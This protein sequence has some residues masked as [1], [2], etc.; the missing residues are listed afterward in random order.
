MKMNESSLG[1][2]MNE[3]NNN[4]TT[5]TFS[6]IFKLKYIRHLI[7]KHVEVISKQ[8]SRPIGDRD[9]K[10]NR[11]LSGREIIKLPNLAMISKYAMPWCFIK[12]YLPPGIDNVLLE[13]RID[14]IIRYCIHR[15]AELDTLKHLI[16][17]WSPDFNPKDRDQATQYF[18]HLALNITLVGNREVLEFILKRYPKLN[19]TNTRPRAAERGYLSI[20]KL[21]DSL[22]SQEPEYTSS[23][24]DKVVANGHLHILE[25]LYN[26]GEDLPPWLINT[27]SANGHLSIVE[28]LHHHDNQNNDRIY[29]AMDRAAQGGFFEIVKFLHFNRAEGCSERAM[30]SAAQIGNL[31]ILKFL[32]LNRTEGCT[33]NAM[34]QASKNGFIDIVIFLH[35]NRTEGCTVNAMDNAN[36]LEIIQY[37]HNHRTEGCT[38]A[39]MARATE[40][41]KLNI[42]QWLHYNRTEGCT[43]DAM[44][45]AIENGHIDIVK[46][47]Y[48]N[49][50]EGCI[51]NILDTAVYRNQSLEMISYVLD[52]IGLGVQF[53]LTTVNY[54]AINGR[55]DLIE[56]FHRHSASL[57]NK[58][59]TTT[60]DFAAKHGR[61]NVVKFLHY[62]RTE[63][64]TSDAMDQAAK[65]GFLD[66]VIFLHENRT[67]GCTTLAMDQNDHFEIVKYLHYNR[68]EGCTFEAIDNLSQF[69]NIEMVKFLHKNRSAGCSDNALNIRNTSDGQLMKELFKYLLDNRLILKDQIQPSHLKHFMVNRVYEVSEFIIVLTLLGISWVMLIVSMGA[70]WYRYSDAFGKVTYINF[71]K[72][73][74]PS[75][76]VL[77]IVY[78]DSNRHYFE[79][80][81]AS[82][83]FSV[84]G[85][86]VVTF[87]I[88]FVI[89]SIVGILGKIP[90]APMGT[91][92]KFLPLVGFLFAFLATFIFVGLPN[93]MY[94]DCKKLNRQCD[95]DDYKFIYDESNGTWGGPYAGWCT[96]VVS[97]ALL[98][99]ASLLSIFLCD[100]ESD[101]NNN[102]KKDSTTPPPP[103]AAETQTPHQPDQQ[104]QH[105]QQAL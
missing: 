102:K 51:I 17:D 66:I 44:D 92:T 63:G 3:T 8:V 90:R 71:E 32:H 43:A 68:T 86:F 47:L 27:A 28:W 52:T 95:R 64:C 81:K 80:F 104:P 58:W 57:P 79:I 50:T 23:V 69:G 18:S 6:T 105:P 82:L 76:N 83:A 42:V 75:G 65:N 77:Y 39:A 100:F 97:M 49:R 53:T 22:A 61:L 13:R 72:M 7:F 91:I 26:Q 60:M 87:N 9:H 54:A 30:N 4:T 15:N 45:N 70:Y 84:M 34:D 11:S 16:D 89:L 46:F 93:A 62:N 88:V 56:Y 31:E 99:A 78:D 12:H 85:W 55:L 5:T 35:E 19:L 67:E 48:E 25:Y 94:R 37:L 38:K 96:A 24:I 20:I 33:T 10:A 41:G 59:A 2:D 98:L 1:L 73:K 101:N 14:V 103:A 74:V 36:S 40:N 21:L 29:T